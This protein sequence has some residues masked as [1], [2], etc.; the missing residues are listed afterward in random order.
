[1]NSFKLLFLIWMFSSTL[2][3][4]NIS[5]TYV[6]KTAGIENDTIV[7]EISFLN[8]STFVE[9][10]FVGDKTGLLEK[11]ETWPVKKTQGIVKKEKSFYDLY[12]YNSYNKLERRYRFKI[13]R[14]SLWLYGLNSKNL[15]YSRVKPVTFKRKACL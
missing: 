10:N 6:W 9:R 15:K 13:K 4:Q 11:Y 1:M 2:N 14:N 3:S 7:S 5:G 8:D 12:I